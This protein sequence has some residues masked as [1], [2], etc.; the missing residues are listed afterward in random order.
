MLYSFEHKN[1][2]CNLNCSLLAGAL[3][4]AEEIAS[5]SP[6][7]VQGTKRNLVYSRD[8]TAQEGLDHIVSAL[9]MLKY[10]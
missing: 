4:L 3:A 8:R 7:A 6:V 2:N 1:N 10:T 9:S 5:K